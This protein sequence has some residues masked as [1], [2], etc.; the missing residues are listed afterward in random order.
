MLVHCWCRY[1]QSLWK[2]NSDHRVHDFPADQLSTQQRIPPRH[3]F[4]LDKDNDDY[5]R[6]HSPDH[7]NSCRL[8]L[9]LRPSPQVF[10]L[11]RESDLKP[12]HAGLN[13]HLRLVLCSDIA[14][15]SVYGFLH[16]LQSA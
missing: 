4:L 15:L 10:R 8:L 12:F 1:W 5:D 6:P 16:D 2:C 7:F 13:Y 3:Y 11:K 14:F 9:K